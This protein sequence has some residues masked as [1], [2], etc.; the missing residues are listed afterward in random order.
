[1]MAHQYIS[2]SPTIASELQCPT[3]PERLAF[4]KGKQ[5]SH[6][7]AKYSFSILTLSKKSGGGPKCLPRGPGPQVQFF[8]E[9]DH[10]RERFSKTSQAGGYVV[11][12]C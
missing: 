7:L 2:S 3:P 4:N 11:Y 9:T 12:I 1:M 5:H 6:N 10:Q 8:G